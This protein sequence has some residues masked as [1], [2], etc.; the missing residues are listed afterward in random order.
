MR[1]FIFIILLIV[2]CN[3]GFNQSF[4][5]PTNFYAFVEN[6]SVYLFWQAPENKSLL[7]YNIYYYGYTNGQHIQI[8]S[9]TNTSF[10]IP[11]PTFSYTI[12]L[13][14]SAEYIEPSGESDTLWSYAICPWLWT[15]P[16]IIDFEEPVVYSCGMVANIIEGNVN[17]E[18]SDSIYYS[19]GHSA[20]FISDSTYSKSSLI[21]TLFGLASSQTPKLSLMCKL[22]GNQGLTDTLKLYYSVSG[23]WIQI[24]DPIT[25]IN[26]WQLLTYN[27]ESLPLSFHFAFEATSGGGNG[28]FLDDIFFE[29]KEVLVQNLKF[30]KDLMKIILDRSSSKLT[31][32]LKIKIKTKCKITLSSINGT[33]V[34]SY[35]NKILSPENHQINIDISSLR[36]GVYIASAKFDNRILTK[37]VIIH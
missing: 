8:G 32:D 7:H 30:E 3:T 21:T 26:D 6:D 29:D 27:L 22:P 14:V 28:V 36:S 20:A 15:L 33:V 24:S 23:N 13:G 2:T 12:N 35:I 11:Q 18:L 17:W 5:P 1:K 9:T 19:Q 37:K 31:I 16:V 25:T 34:K 10:T 4:P